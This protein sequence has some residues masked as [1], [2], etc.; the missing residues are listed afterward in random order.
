[1]LLAACGGPPSGGVRGGTATAPVAATAPA[2]GGATGAAASPARAGGGSGCPMTGTAAGSLTRAATPAVGPAGAGEGEVYKIGANLDVSG[3]G[4]SLGVPERNT[5]QLLEKQVNDAGGILGPDGR[6]HKVQV[7]FYDNQSDNAQS[8]QVTRRLI[9]EDK[10]AVV[11]G[12]T[13]TATT[14]AVTD[15]ATKGETPLISLA[16]GVQIVEP[17]AERKWIFK[18]PQS[19]PL[20]ICTVLDRLRAKGHKKAAFL[21]VND[22]FGESGRNE[23]NRLVQGYGIQTVVDDRFGGEDKDMTTQLNRVKNSDA[24]VLIIWGIPPAA[25]IATK[26]YGDLGMKI[27][28]YLSHGVANRNYIELSGEAANGVFFPAGKL[29]VAETLADSDPQKPVLIQYAKDYEGAYGAGTRN[30]FGGHAWDAFQI[31]VLAMNK[32]GNDRAKIRDEIERVRDF[33]GITGVFNFSPQDHNGLDQRAVTMV[34]IEGG[35]WKTAAP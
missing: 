27:P 9:E 23:W 14:L 19:D 34:T 11:I 12:A 13:R 10:V 31:A 32:A 1:M 17:V 15:Q 5:L 33:V 22:A 25:A 24:E 8:I 26:N 3:V 30:T 18:T 29:L 16:A 20:M 6:R 4:S 21:S 2:G 28:L 35:N 7:I